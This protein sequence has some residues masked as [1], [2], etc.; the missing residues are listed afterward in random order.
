M[1]IKIKLTRE[2]NA[3]YFH[4]N[5]GDVVTIPLELYLLGVVAAEAV[6]QYPH[7]SMAQ[8]VASRTFAYPY[9]LK[10]KPITDSSSSHQAFRADLMHHS[11]Y[12]VAHQAVQDTEGE[13]LYYGNE[14]VSPCAFS[15]CNRG[16]T[17]S[18][19]SRWGG[20]R[21]YL[22]EQDDPWDKTAGYLITRGHGVGMSQYGA[23]EAAKQGVSYRDILSF[24]YPGTHI[25]K[26]GSPM[27]KVKASDL[28]VIFKQMADEHWKYVAG[29]RKR[30]EVDCSGAFY[31]AYKQLGDYMY[32]GSNTMWRKY[33]SKK[34]KIGEIDLKPGMAVFKCRKWTSAQSSN[35]WYETDPGDVYHVGL[36]IGDGL[37]VEAQ[38]KKT[39]VVKTK[40]STWHLA[41]ELIDTTY[42]VAEGEKPNANAFEQTK[43]GVVR[44]N[45]GYLNLRIGP[46][47]SYPYAEKAYNGDAL[48]I[49]GEESNWYKVD[50]FGKALYASKTYVE[51]VD[52][53]PAKQYVFTVIVNEEDK[54]DLENILAD[55]VYNI[56]EVG[57]AA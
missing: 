50:Y 52:S 21:P 19:E 36:Y 2:E 53:K 33:T 18:S 40:I 31:Y 34:G 7:A 12:V 35:G 11:E 6:V 1:D 26:E 16:R 55:Y 43:T 9:A 39:G 17:T 46:S 8:A 37:V 38:S 45:N 22:I 4:A 47:T 41:A 10:D 27:A 20:Y 49:V 42:D 23:H 29:A 54:T 57:D 28:I 30:G 24:Y 56:K 14:L 48:T 51:L 3:E 5:V 15:S 25:V 32:H 13:I 44:V